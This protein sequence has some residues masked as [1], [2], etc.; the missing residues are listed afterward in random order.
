MSAHV[1]SPPPSRTRGPEA[2]ASRLW[3]IATICPSNLG[4]AERRR[5]VASLG[6]LSFGH[7]AS[8]PS[9]GSWPS[10]R[11][12]LEEKQKS[13]QQRH[14]LQPF[15]LFLG[16]R[17]KTAAPQREHGVVAVHED[18]RRCSNGHRRPHRCSGQAA[19]TSAIAEPSSSC[20]TTCRSSCSWHAAIYM[21][22]CKKDT[23]MN[24][25]PPMASA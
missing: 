3:C 5:R 2:L 21:N 16:T 19:L 15:N 6:P 13:P 9:A 17:S 1:S 22:F 4:R 20:A 18:L 7:R 14:G 24:C 12:R 25:R 11:G 10:C 23:P 8:G